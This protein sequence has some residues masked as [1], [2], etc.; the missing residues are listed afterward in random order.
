[1]VDKKVNFG[2]SEYRI[3]PSEYSKMTEKGMQ[4]KEIKGFN[5]ITTEEII[6]ALGGDKLSQEQKTA[7]EKMFN[8][9]AGDDGKISSDELQGYFQKLAEAA[10]DDEMLSRYEMEEFAKAR[11]E[12][13]KFDD[14]LF[15]LPKEKFALIPRFIKALVGINEEKLKAQEQEQKNIEENTTVDKKG[16]RTY[17]QKVDEEGPNF[18]QIV[19]RF[20]T[21]NPAGVVIAKGYKTRNGITVT[22]K[23]ENGIRK[24]TTEKYAGGDTRTYYY[25][26]NPNI[27][28]QLV[29]KEVYKDINGSVSTTDYTYNA[30]G[31]VTKKVYKDNLTSSTT[32]YKYNAEGKKTQEIEK[33]GNNVA[34]TTFDANEKKT[35]TVT[36][37]GDKSSVTGIYN[38]DD[39]DNPTK[40]IYKNSDGQVERVTTYKRNADGYLLEAIDRA[41]DNP[42][43]P[44]IERR[45]MEK[46]CYSDVDYNSNDGMAE[47]IEYDSSGKN[48][49]RKTTYKNGYPTEK[50]E[51]LKDGN[52][53]ITTYKP[54]SDIPTAQVLKK[55]DNVIQTTE[56]KYDGYN[57]LSL[58]TKDGQGKE[59]KSI[60]NTYTNGKVTKSVIKENG[61]I[62]LTETSSYD[63]NDRQVLHV[64]QYSDGRVTRYDT[65]H[66]NDNTTVTEVRNANNKSQESLRYITTQTLKDNLWHE[67]TV[68]YKNGQPA[69]IQIENDDYDKNTHELKYTDLKGNPISEEEFK[70]LI[71]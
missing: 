65:A 70:N 54:D 2:I 23:Y 48:I 9:I 7:Y 18:T 17:H 24:S 12:Y 34:T 60:E 47:R 6:K 1:M 71:K 30:Q 41:S 53:E 67:Q 43:A 45:I 50:T 58:V 49:I 38:P 69:A 55:G 61:E 40:K 42:K 59:I 44:I 3:G 46:G 31:K 66:P 26:N 37:R 56:Y 29:T 14:H 62:T 68:Y 19:E 27:E 39:S 8:N 13:P 35:K 57:L 51:Q 10:G 21:K 5:E 64:F 52:T 32:D 15:E 33:Y 25:N 16:N 4:K 28:E 22:D 11:G 20:E 63:A 36:V